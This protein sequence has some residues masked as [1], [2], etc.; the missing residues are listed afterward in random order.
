MVDARRAAGWLKVRRVSPDEIRPRCVISRGW[1]V[2]RLRGIS[3]CWWRCSSLISA[4]A[5][6]HRL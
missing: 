1:A 5:S 4:G 3:N 6:S 2:R